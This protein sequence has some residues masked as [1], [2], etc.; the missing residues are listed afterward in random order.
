MNEAITESF[1][2]SKNS[3]KEKMVEALNPKYLQLK[4]IL[5]K[6]IRDE[7]FVPGIKLPTQRELMSKYRISYSTVNRALL[8]LVHEGVLYRV[9]GRGTFVLDSQARRD[10]P[11]RHIAIVFFTERQQL[12]TDPF[13]TEIF[14][15]MEAEVQKRGC[16]SLFYTTN[17]GVNSPLFSLVTKGEIAGVILLAHWDKVLFRELKKRVIPTVGVYF[18]CDD[19]KI[20][21]IVVDNH[22]GAYD[23]T[24]YLLDLGHRKIAFVG[25]SSEN[26]EERFE[27]YR[28]ALKERKVFFNYR[29]VGSYHSHE[30]GRIAAKRILNISSRPTAVLFS[31]D[32]LAIGAMK[33]FREEGVNIPGDIS[34]IGFND[35]PILSYLEPPLTSVRVAKREMGEEAVKRLFMAIEGKGEGPAKIMIPTKLI[36]RESCARQGGNEIL[37]AINNS[38][39]TKS[40]AV[41]PAMVKQGK[42]R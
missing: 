35:T 10:S 25:Y 31:H 14:E 18:Y 17:E 42:E 28:L 23:A 40:S 3:G 2:K 21:Y 20:D 9:Q 29:I 41:L 5:I 27:G 12:Y 33:Q 6:Q 32:D 38:E 34:I 4:E 8:E 11:K 36:I 15:G 39:L 26:S 37:P 7:K 30:D 22:K 1:Y 24:K 19:V 16:N 13:Y